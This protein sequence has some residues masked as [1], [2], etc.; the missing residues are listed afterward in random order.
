MEQIPRIKTVK[1]IGGVRL[2]VTF[3]SGVKKIYDCESLLA[4]SQFHLLGSPAFFNA[5]HVDTGG[6][7]ISW[8]DDIDLSEYE[9]W[10]NGKTATNK[11][12]KTEVA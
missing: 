1:T 3:D 12:L 4:R 11:L 10:T 6:Y 8:S 5:V 7:G 9:L 2:L